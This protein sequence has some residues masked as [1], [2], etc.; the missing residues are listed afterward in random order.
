MGYTNESRKLSSAQVNLHAQ[1]GFKHAV[2][3]KYLRTLPVISRFASKIM[4]DSNLPSV[5]N[6]NISRIRAPSQS[7]QRLEPVLQISSKGTRKLRVRQ[8]AMLFV[9]PR[10][11]ISV[12]GSAIVLQDMLFGQVTSAAW[13]EASHR[14]P[15]QGKSCSRKDLPPSCHCRCLLLRRFSMKYQRG[16]RSLP[17]GHCPNQWEAVPL[18]TRATA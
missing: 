6:I 13:S 4:A 17:P 7:D 5:T 14:D 15:G 10:V 16:N 1:T 2:S 18:P 8:H 11:S 9:E 12:L 3:P